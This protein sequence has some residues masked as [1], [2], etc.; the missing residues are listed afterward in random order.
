[1]SEGDP[2]YPNLAV[3]PCDAKQ[4]TRLYGSVIRSG[5]SARGQ[6]VRRVILSGRR[7][8]HSRWDGREIVGQGA[9]ISPLNR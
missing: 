2:R 9:E 5:L 7:A 3:N 8:R 4:R 6:R 1:M